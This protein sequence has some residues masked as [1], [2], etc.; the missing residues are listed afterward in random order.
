MGFLMPDEFIPLAEE[1]GMIIEIDQWVMQTAMKSVSQWYKEGLNPGVLGINLSVKQLEKTDFIQKVETCM[2]KNDFDPK[3]LEL[4]ITERQMMKKSDEV[5]TKLHQIHD[6][7]ISI[8]IDDFGTGYS[9]LSLLKRLPIN[10]LK[11]DRSFVQKIGQEDK[12]TAIVNALIAM[13]QSMKIG[14]IAEGVETEEQIDFLTSLNC[15]L[16]QGYYFSKPLSVSGIEQ[17]MTKKVV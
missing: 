11:I 2:K 4:E 16:Y 14:V 12:S 5:N 3:W 1:T 13:A 9:S 8:S 17:W 15:H 7:G 6:L 10:R